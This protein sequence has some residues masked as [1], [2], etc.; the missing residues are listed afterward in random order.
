MSDERF[1]CGVVTRYRKECVE[2]RRVSVTHTKPITKTSLMSQYTTDNIWNYDRTKL[3][4]QNT[5]RYT[6][7]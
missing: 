3:T 7:I 1:G 5:C 6:V 2:T 4:L